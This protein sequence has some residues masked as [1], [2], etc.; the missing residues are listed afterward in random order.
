MGLLAN[1]TNRRGVLYELQST[2]RFSRLMSVSTVAKCYISTRRSLGV[3][4]QSSEDDPKLNNTSSF[5]Y[6]HSVI[7]DPGITCD[8]LSPLHGHSFTSVTA[9][10]FPAEEVV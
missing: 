1:P 8:F 2:Q 10:E 6:K 5:S 9:C 3:C 7:E 4:S